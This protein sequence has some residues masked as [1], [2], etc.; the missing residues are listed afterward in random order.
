VARQPHRK[1]NHRRVRSGT[2]L[3][4]VRLPRPELVLVADLL[5]HAV[6]FYL[7]A[8]HQR[9]DKVDARW[10]APIL[11]FS[12][13]MLCVRNVEAVA[14][15]ARHD[16]VLVTAAWANARNAFELA[17]RVQWLLYPDDRFEAEMRWIAFL[18]EYERF[19]E[20]TSG[21]PLEDCNEALRSHRAEIG[22]SIRTFREGVQFAVPTGYRPVVG[23]PSIE[24]MLR[25][26]G[27]QDLYL[28]YIEGSQFLHGSMFAA[29][30]YI[31]NLGTEKAW[32]EFTQLMQ[33]ILPMRLCWLSLRESS[34]IVLR[35]MLHKPFE[36]NWIKLNSEMDSAF[37]SLTLAASA[38]QA[39]RASTDGEYE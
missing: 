26:T 29:S 32:G 2:T 33:W 20:R 25:E 37:E 19:F 15:L 12:L 4:I 39:D 13:V 11:G 30:S 10:E 17:V 21:R 9:M 1:P 31:K 14:L 8:Y 7:E 27:S 24:G 35:K 6:S 23:I 28:A 34:S 16:E 3:N 22:A 18:H 38:E 36:L 5:D